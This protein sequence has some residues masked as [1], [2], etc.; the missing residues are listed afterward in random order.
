MQNENSYA[1]RF[2][3]AEMLDEGE[4]LHR[5]QPVGPFVVAL[6]ELTGGGYANRAAQPA[7][8]LRNWSSKADELVNVEL[9]GSRHYRRAALRFNSLVDDELA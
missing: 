6:I 7:V 1:W 2:A 5:A 8:V 3:Q 4:T 9:Y